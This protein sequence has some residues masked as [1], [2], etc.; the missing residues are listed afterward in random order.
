VRSQEPIG[1]ED[2]ARVAGSPDVMGSSVRLILTNA[3]VLIEFDAN[4]P[5]CRY[6]ETGFEEVGRIGA[7]K[8]ASVRLPVQA[9]SSVMPKRGPD[10]WQ[11]FMR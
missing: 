3:L 2:S 10:Q 4:F 9:R 5:V 1:L 8:S 6:P 7:G 11:P